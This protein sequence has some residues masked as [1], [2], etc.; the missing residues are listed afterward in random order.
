MTGGVHLVQTPRAEVERVAR[1]LDETLKL[2]RVA[3]GHCT[4]ELGFQVFLDRFMD[5]LRFAC[6]G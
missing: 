4:S 6:G 3:P 1:L 2:P 5:R